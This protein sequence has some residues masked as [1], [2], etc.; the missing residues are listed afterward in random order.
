MSLK[1]KDFFEE[2]RAL[3]WQIQ[4]NDKSVA[5]ESL[6][7]GRL[8]NAPDELRDFI[9]YCSICANPDDTV[10]FLSPSDYVDGADIAFPWNEFENQS[11]QYADK[12]ELEKIDIFWKTHI[13]FL[14]SVKNGYSYLAYTLEGNNK[15]K[16]VCGYE[17]TYEEVSFIA[18][19]LDEFK[20]E[21]I[22]ALKGTGSS[23]KYS[24]VI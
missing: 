14:F 19:S 12:E 6:A 11:K 23:A 18:E 9:S 4:R 17:P 5:W 22:N 16:I 1:N 7:S 10:W 15:G 8:V 20:Q 21:F 2:L 3:G 13:P 24:L